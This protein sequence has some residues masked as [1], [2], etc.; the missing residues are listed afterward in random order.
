MGGKFLWWMFLKVGGISG[1]VNFLVNVS[2][3]RWDFW[4]GEF[5][6]WKGEG[7]GEG[8]ICIGLDS[9]PTRASHQKR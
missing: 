8:G 3:G 4:R 1:V 7:E 5:L 6:W 2:R 9:I